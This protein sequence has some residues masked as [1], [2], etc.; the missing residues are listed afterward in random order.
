MTDDLVQSEGAEGLGKEFVVLG[1]LLGR[2]GLFGVHGH[3][4]GVE[5]G[6][7]LVE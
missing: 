5:L 3:G 6:A 2:G 1:G 4:L 7:G